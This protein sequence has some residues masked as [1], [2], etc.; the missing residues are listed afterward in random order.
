MFKGEEEGEEEEEHLRGQ[1]SR[2]QIDGSTRERESGRTY[3][4]CRQ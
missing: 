1:S 2:K 4:G 3:D